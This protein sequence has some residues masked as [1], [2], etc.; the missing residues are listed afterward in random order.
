MRWASSTAEPET[1]ADLLERPSRYALSHRRADQWLAIPTAHRQPACFWR[2]RRQR[3]KTVY[4]CFLHRE[5][6]WEDSAEP[7]PFLYGGTVPCFW[8]D[9]EAFDPADFLAPVDSWLK[10]A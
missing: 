7:K 6:L 4:P 2:P 1:R 10:A 9:L 5:S 8:A 3:S